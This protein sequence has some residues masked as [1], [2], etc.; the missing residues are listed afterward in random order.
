MSCNLRNPVTGATYRLILRTNSTWDIG[1]NDVEVRQVRVALLQLVDEIRELRDRVLHAHVLVRRP[2]AQ[3]DRSLR[4]A[5]GLDD[6]VH[7]LEAEPRT[8][9]DRAAVL[10]HTLVG[11]ILEELVDEVAIRAVHFHTVE[12]R[13]FDSILGRDRVPTNIL[14]DF[15]G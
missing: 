14:L 8:V 5:D 10:V 11:D 3:A 2:R 9:F 6:S 13:A 4:L 12:A 1:G 15:C 7:D